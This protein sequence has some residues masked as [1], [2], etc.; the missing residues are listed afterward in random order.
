MRVEFY[1]ATRHSF[2]FQV[3]N[4]GVDKSIVQRLLRHTDPKMTVEKMAESSI[5][6]IQL[7]K[8]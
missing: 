8:I 3:L 5:E 2:A 6:N 4:S 1:H 7:F